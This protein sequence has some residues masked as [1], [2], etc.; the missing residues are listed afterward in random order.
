MSRQSQRTNLILLSIL[1]L[2]GAGAAVKTFFVKSSF[3]TGE[4]AA[5][6]ESLFADF[7]KDQVTALVIEGPEDKKAELVKDGDHWNL[8]NDGNFRAD[9]AD[10]DRV[11]NGIEKLKRGKVASNRT[12]KLDAFNLQKG[13]AIE[14][15][16]YGAGGKS[17]AP[18][19]AFSIGKS[20]D[21]WKFAFV[22]LAGG[23]DVA[24]RKVEG[25]T[26][27][28]EAGY[29]NTWRDKTIFDLGDAAKIEEVT[30]TGAKGPVTLQRQKEMGPKDGD[31]PANAAGADP[32][33]IAAKAGAPPDATGDKPDAPKKPEQEV[34]ETY[35]QITAPTAGKAKKWLGDNIATNLAK[36]DCASFFTGTEK[37]SDLGLDPPAFVAAVRREGEKEAKPVLYIGNKGKDQKYP[38]K[39]PDDPTI[40]WIDS[41]KGDYLT[42]SADE[43]IDAPPPPKPDEKKPEEKK[44]DEAAPTGDKKGEDAP[45]GDATPA[46][47]KSDGGEAKPAEGAKPAGDAKPEGSGKPDGGGR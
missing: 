30:I 15:T 33:D 16:A 31:K 2:L 45:K 43:L 4:T 17:S 39:R 7:K 18:V 5:A 22:R 26:S 3:E 29:D 32:T 44:P 8:V 1:G 6:S 34:K 37:P 19:A 10:V 36:L 35:W 20:G 25:S 46:P 42:K 21:E 23:K 24:V 38:V 12:D 11:L 27:D 40:W 13:K 9:K 28:F 47:P 41:W 14:V